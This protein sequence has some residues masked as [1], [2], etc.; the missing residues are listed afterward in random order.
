MKQYGADKYRSFDTEPAIK[1]ARAFEGRVA[2]AEIQMGLEELDLAADCDYE[3]TCPI[4]G[5]GV[6]CDGLGVL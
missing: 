4:C 2:D 5:P 1:S 3:L 6:A